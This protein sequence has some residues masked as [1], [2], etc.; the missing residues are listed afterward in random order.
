MLVRM[1]TGTFEVL[2][3]VDRKITEIETFT[4]CSFALN[5]TC[6]AVHVVMHFIRVVAETFG[7]WADVLAGKLFRIVPGS[8][9]S[10]S[11]LLCI[12]LFVLSVLFFRH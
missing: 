8:V 12:V 10:V 5:F 9:K 7:R 1:F 2:G 6:A 3:T 4:V 11:C